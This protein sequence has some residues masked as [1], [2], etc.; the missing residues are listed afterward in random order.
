MLYEYL[1][2]LISAVIF[3]AAIYY[4]DNKYPRS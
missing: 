3:V 4:V 2:I 1:N